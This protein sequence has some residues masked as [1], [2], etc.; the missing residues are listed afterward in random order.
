MVGSAATNMVTPSAT[1]GA[2][3]DAHGDGDSPSRTTTAN[4]AANGDGADEENRP[5]QASS[6]SALDFVA[7]ELNKTYC[8]PPAPPCE[9]HR[10]K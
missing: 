1:T 10:M 6:Q 7:A 4:P 8:A 2:V 5:T 3:S 9:A